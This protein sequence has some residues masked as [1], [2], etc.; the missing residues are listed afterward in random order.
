MK[1]NTLHLV[2]I[3]D[4]KIFLACN[5]IYFSLRLHEDWAGLGWAL[6]HES[7]DT[8]SLAAE[9]AAIWALCSRSRAKSQETGPNYASTLKAS[10]RTQCLSLSLTFQ[11][12]KQ[13]SG[14]NSIWIP[15]QCQSFGPAEG[16]GKEVSETYGSFYDLINKDITEKKL[17]A[18]W[19]ICIDRGPS[20]S[21]LLMPA[22]IT[23]PLKLGFQGQGPSTT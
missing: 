18:S 9:A 3:S 23:E 13:C 17:K 19:S 7:Y 22:S 8:G 2:V 11:W 1:F 6:L 5:H 21:S 14:S 10:P 4:T 20:P 15:E 12:P 16:E